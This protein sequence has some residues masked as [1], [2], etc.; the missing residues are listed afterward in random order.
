MKNYVSPA[1]RTVCADTAITGT[2]WD[3]MSFDKLDGSLTAND[4]STT[5][6]VNVNIP[7]NPE[8]EI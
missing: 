2:F 3:D 1:V 7:N 4:S 5:S 8:G 6:V